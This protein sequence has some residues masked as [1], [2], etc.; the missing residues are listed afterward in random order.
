MSKQIA[1]TVG[2]KKIA[3]L[4]ALLAAFAVLASL[5][6]Q[7]NGAR[8]N[9]TGGDFVVTNS[10]PGGGNIAPNQTVTYTVTWT[11]TGSDHVGSTVIAGTLDSELIA[12]VFR[13]AGC[14]VIIETPP[15]AT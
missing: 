15:T 10:N 9:V 14:D 6:T 3:V 13:D 4:I 2:D 1:Q 7:W 8:G 5:A 12:A 11:I